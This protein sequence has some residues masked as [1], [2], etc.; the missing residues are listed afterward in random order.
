MLSGVEP[1]SA[2]LAEA[3]QLVDELGD[4]ALRARLDYQRANIHGRVGD[5]ASA[6][7]GLEGA[8]RRLD[9]FTEREQCSVHLS[10]G[11]LAFELLRPQEAL[12]SFA[13]AARLAHD[14]G[15]PP[16]SSWRGTTRGMP[17]T[18]SV[19]SRG[20]WPTWRS[21]RSS[22][23]TSSAV[24]RASTGRGCCSRR[25]S[26]RRPSRHCT[27][28]SPAST[29]DGHDQMR[30]EF[31]LDLARA[32]RLL[33]H[34]DL[35]AEAAASARETY[36]RIGATAWAAKAMLVGLLVDL[37]RQR[38]AAARAGAAGR[39]TWSGASSVSGTPRWRSPRRRRPTS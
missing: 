15:G 25:G 30:A 34:L 19:T 14:L 13:E 39:P 1:A 21:R 20:R 38:R 3:E 36:A 31:E 33:G 10:R 18:S 7:D 11:M 35:A 29:G 32:H 5:L 4:D 23:P 12:E 28:G 24:R 26:S 6:W 16:R 22:S 27:R 37:D 17:R 9:A 8:V 2:R